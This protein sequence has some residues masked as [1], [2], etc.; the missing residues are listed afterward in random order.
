MIIVLLV[1]LYQVLATAISLYSFAILIYVLMSWIPGAR[2][3]QFGELLGR[4]CDPYLE[5]FQRYI[6]PIGFIDISPIIALIVLQLANRGLY[7][8]FS[9]LM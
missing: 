3:T 4:I 8:L 2:S 1:A 7:V 5:F 9:F 6:P